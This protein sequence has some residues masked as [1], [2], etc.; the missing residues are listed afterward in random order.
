MALPGAADF[1]P[2]RSRTGTSTA[3][4]ADRGLSRGRRRATPARPVHTV[5]ERQAARLGHAGPRAG[6]DPVI[7]EILPCPVVVSCVK[8]PL[9]FVM[10]L[11]DFPGGIAVRVLDDQKTPEAGSK[12]TIDSRRDRWRRAAFSAMAPP[13]EC[14]IRWNR[15]A[16]RKTGSSRSTSS[17]TRIPRPPGQ[18]GVLP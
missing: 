10:T 3:A 13:Q 18:G 5:G 17:S 6:T 1:V 14:P 8:Q 12:S 16:S 2:D 7:D 9:C 4:K 15:S 11:R